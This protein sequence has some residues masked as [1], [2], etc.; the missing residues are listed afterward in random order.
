MNLRGTSALPVPDPGAT[1]GTGA[2]QRRL[3]PALCRPLGDVNAAMRD[4]DADA[5]RVR[6]LLD[7]G[8]LVGFN[9]GARDGG[10][11]TV[12]VLTQ[13]IEHYLETGAPL[14]LAWEQIFRFLIPHD[15]LF[16]RG[17]E[18]ERALNCDRG[19]VENLI[20]AKRFTCVKQPR[21]GPG[22]SPMVTRESFQAFMKGRML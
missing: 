7:E 13:S 1:P 20:R 6:A 16:L 21:F 8:K 19:L 3:H 2:G 22:G 11:A 17:P 18:I 4:L 15:K 14:S 12:R 5:E 9:I 10:R